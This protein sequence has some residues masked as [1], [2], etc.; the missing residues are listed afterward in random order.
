MNTL[1]NNE[2]VNRI[3]KAYSYKISVIELN[4]P[5]KFLDKSIKNYSLENYNKDLTT[6]KNFDINLLWDKS[7]WNIGVSTSICFFAA[8]PYSKLKQ[9]LN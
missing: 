9:L 7:F 6:L 4:T 3:N 2:V 5:T 1:N 8:I